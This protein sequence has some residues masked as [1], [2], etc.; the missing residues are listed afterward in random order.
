[1]CSYFGWSGEAQPQHAVRWR[2]AIGYNRVMCLNFLFS[3]SEYNSPSYHEIA[4][5]GH[6]LHR[7]TDAL[8]PQS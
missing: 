4:N 7:E 2:T 8:A 3:A 6:V 1:M 5:F